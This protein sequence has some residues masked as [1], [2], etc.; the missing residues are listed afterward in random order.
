MAATLEATSPPGARAYHQAVELL[1]TGE[2]QAGTRLLAEV[3]RHTNEDPLR[4]QALFSLAEVFEQLDEA[5][6]AYQTW[7]ALA[8]KP[9]V[10]RNKFDLAARQ[11]VLGLFEQRALRLRPPDFPPRLQLE[12]TNLCNLRCVMCTRNQMT[13]GTGDMTIETLRRAADE[14]CREPG[15]VLCLY[16][17][18]EPLLHKGLEEMIHY[19][20]A[21]K[22]RALVPMT[23]G[24]QSNGMLMTP[25]R[26]RSLLEAGMRSVAFSVDGLEG[27]LERV[28]PGAS[29]PV[30]EEN[31]LGLVRT[32]REMGIDDLQVDITKLCDDRNADEVKR[33][34]ER[35]EGKVDNVLLSGITKAEGNSYMTADGTIELITPT[36]N[37]KRRVYCLQGNRLLV[38]WNGDFG[39]CCGDINGQLALGNIRDR[40]VREVWNGPEI[41]R[42]REKILAADYNGLAACRTCPHSYH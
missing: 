20:D 21:V 17:L 8:H 10:D 12:V 11:R 5:E 25:D 27:D 35:W 7:Y 22:D 23:F 2:V 4:S 42:I 30:V 32:A 31:I 15:C 14:W 41:Q 39:F 19:V 16:F 26:A 36:L 1:R 3:A 24:M 33:F 37:E 6:H 9:L 18:G 28:R 29:Y 40:S 13:R 38:Y 34:V